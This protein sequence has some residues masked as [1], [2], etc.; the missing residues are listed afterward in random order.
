MRIGNRII[1]DQDGEI[2]YQTGDME[3]DVLPRKE[4][5]EL[6]VVDLDFGAINYQTHELVR[7]DVATNQ[8]IL[9][10]IQREKTQEEIIK[11]LEDQLLLV[12]DNEVGGIL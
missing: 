1:C 9:R 4:I 2:I 8:P 10:E 3:G 6:H 12:T 5:T 11:E 7:I